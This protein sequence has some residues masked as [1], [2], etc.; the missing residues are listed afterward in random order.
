MKKLFCTS[1]VKRYMLSL[2]ENGNIIL[3]TAKGDD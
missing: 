1:K 2:D 3:K